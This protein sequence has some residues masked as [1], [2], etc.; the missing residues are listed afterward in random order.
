MSVTPGVNRYEVV[1][2]NKYYL[3]ELVES[4]EL[5]ESLDEIAYRATVRLRVT[6]DFP[7]IV[8]GQQ[9]RVSG[10]PFGETQMVYLLQPGVVWEIQSVKTGSKTL[11][12]TI[13]DRAIYL[14]KSEDEYLLP[15]G[16]TASQRLK[17]YAADWGIPLG[18]IVDTGVPLA[19]AVYR[20]QSIWNMIMSD[21]KETVRKG[22]QMYRPRMVPDVG[23]EL[24]PLGSNQTVWALEEDRN[25]EEIDQTRTLEGAITQV[26]ILGNADNDQ[27]SPVIGL[28]DQDTDKYG[29]IQK[30]YQDPQMTDAGA[31]KQAAQTMLTGVQETFSVTAI[32][33]NTIRAGDRVK[34]NGMDLY[35]MSVTHRL[36]SP[37]TMNLEL[38]WPDV[39]KRRVYGY[40]SVA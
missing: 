35:V 12:V 18:N 11:T 38:T 9:I 25:I 30:V 6:P 17:I 39:I 29:T 22:G 26:K 8:N 13:Y 20:A 28:V 5:S 4:I 33:I 14:S 32:D 21:L 36:G 37:G 1:L 34:L 15:E 3:R 31:A 10:T 19:K 27:K 24:V 40:G 16:Q 2:D 23:I 7:G